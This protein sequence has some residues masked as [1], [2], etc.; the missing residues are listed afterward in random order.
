MCWAPNQD[1]APLFQ[2]RKTVSSTLLADSPGLRGKED[3]PLG[4]WPVPLVGRS[5][6]VPPKDRRGTHLEE[7]HVATE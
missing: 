6:D 2:P 7:D 4:M 1:Q 3:Q 5:R